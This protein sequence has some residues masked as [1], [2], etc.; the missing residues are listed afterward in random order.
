MA[1]T[2]GRE[3]PREA[4]SR[5]G[6]PLWLKSQSHTINWPARTVWNGKAAVPKGEG[7]GLNKNENIAMATARAARVHQPPMS[8]RGYHPNQC[9]HVC[10]QQVLPGN[11]CPPLSLLL[12]WLS[13]GKPATKAFAPTKLWKCGFWG[14]SRAAVA[15]VRGAP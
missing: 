15:C 4:L 3:G 5:Q 9:T 12:L 14:H 2:A 1:H 11:K 8:Q 13:P 10:T 7:A 6:P